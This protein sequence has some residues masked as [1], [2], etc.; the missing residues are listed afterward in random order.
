MSLSFKIEA[1]TSHKANQTAPRPT[2]SALTSHPKSRTFN[3]DF[4]SSEDEDAEQA[5]QRTRRPELITEFDSTRP[6]KNE[7]RP[8]LLIPALPDRDFRAIHV[9]R[10]A[11]RTKKELY[12][13]EAVNSFGTIRTTDS[14][15]AVN[16]PEGVD[17]VNSKTISGGLEV[18]QQLYGKAN[19]LE[20]DSPATQGGGAMTPLEK[21]TSNCPTP[22]EAEKPDTRLA[23][24]LEEKALRELI[25]QAGGSLEA[26]R[27]EIQAIVMSD[28]TASDSD[29]DASVDE[30]TQFRRDVSK[31]P[32]PSSLEDYARVPVGQFGLAMLK[33]MGWKEGTS[34]SKRGRVGLVEAYVPQARPSLLGIGAKQLVLE[35]D[36]NAGGS[37][38]SKDK[39]IPRPERRYV[40][41]LRKVIDHGRSEVSN[42]SDCLCLF[43][44]MIL[45]ADDGLCMCVSVCVCVQR[46][47]TFRILLLLAAPALALDP[48]H[49]PG[50]QIIV[51]GCQRGKSGTNTHPIMGINV[52]T[53]AVQMV[54]EYTRTIDVLETMIDLREEQTSWV[55]KR[56]DMR[57]IGLT[58]IALVVILRALE[59]RLEGTI[60]MMMVHIQATDEDFVY[61]LFG[62]LVGLNLLDYVRFSL[63]VVMG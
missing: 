2:S 45:G 11:K 5:G 23:S 39:K 34:T 24:T 63:A 55:E 20:V 13:P 1:P 50:A 35:G 28:P 10:K 57:T 19:P 56:S 54:G 32:D 60:E 46:C 16:D 18:R 49:L 27:P 62:Q 58:K 48:A 38:G 4:R 36:G 9:A 3:G 17:K 6:T 14:S 61:W 40:P 42:G 15:T 53:S 43:L 33:G 44:S 37:G 29:S 52:I 26:E 30:T 59:D 7:K 47:A 51:I 31:R 22:V 21:L 41:L 12:K 8:E 25:S